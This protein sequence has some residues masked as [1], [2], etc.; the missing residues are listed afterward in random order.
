MSLLILEALSGN[1]HRVTIVEEEWDPLPLG[2]KWDLVGITTMTAT[3]PRAYELAKIF[4]E[5]GAR[6]ILGGIHP[7]VLPEE[8]SQ[9]ADAVLV[10]EAEGI[11]GRVLEDAARGRLQ[12]FYVNLKPET[13]HVP[14]VNY[15]SNGST[16]P[17]AAPVIAG[18]GCPFGCEFC[19]VP[20][21]YG[22]LLRKVPVD[23]IVEQVR[24]SRSDYLAFLDD[25]LAA[26]REHSQDLFTVLK[27]LQAK[28]IAQV[29]VRFIL[30]DEL[31]HLAVEAGLKGVF[32]GFETIE[33]KSLAHLRKSV[34]LEKYALAIKKCRDAGVMLFGSFIFG[35]DE[36]DST[37]FKRTLDFIM[38][39][40]IPTV[41]AHVLTP[42]PGTALFDR[43]AA[44]GRLLHR[45]WAFYDHGTP[46]FIPAR[47][48]V[49]ELVQGYLKFR[50]SLFGLKGTAYRLFA[51]ISVNPLVYLHFNAASRR[52]TSRLKD[53]YKNYFNWL[54]SSAAPVWRGQ[55]LRP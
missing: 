17:M 24:R 35:L 44:E 31:F 27:D 49:E 30:D 36:Q 9:H 11:W 13:L 23:W 6:V 18:R 20:R 34:P 21:I 16:G 8:A 19:S 53:H 55:G 42:Y 48:T 7:S 10:G 54:Q 43:L 47:M 3:A 46:V 26:D 33:E 14:L 45:N 38:K 22:T 37:I 4:R 40:Q 28:F 25:N 12:P 41:G 50:K 32:V 2:E 1:G 5:R 29:P 15:N 51:G 52:I 39:H